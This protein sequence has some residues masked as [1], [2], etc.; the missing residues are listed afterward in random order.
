M[1]FLLYGLNMNNNTDHT[2]IL[3]RSIAA[4]FE[5]P[6]IKIIAEAWKLGKKLVRGLS[7]EGIYEVLDY[8][9]TLELLDSKGISAKFQKRKKVRYLQNN[10]ITFQDHAWGDGEILKNY[11]TSTGVL[12]DKYRLGYK[13]HVLLSLREVKNKGDVDTFNISWEIHRGFLE[14]D[15]FWDTDITQRTKKICVHVIFPKNRPPHRVTIRETNRQRTTYLGHEYRKRL[16]DGR[17]KV[18]WKKKNP[19]LYEHYLMKWRW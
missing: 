1:I 3:A 13:T 16:S 14:S 9:S 6:W 10:V 18:T 8:E 17:I 12:V 15:G 4:L 5:L 2:K 19:N 7:L 11:K